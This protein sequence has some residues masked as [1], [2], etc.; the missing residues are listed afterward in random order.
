[1]QVYPKAFHWIIFSG[2]CSLTACQPVSSTP[3]SKVNANISG[4]STLQLSAAAKEKVGRKIW[5]NESGG[6]LEGL[7]QWNDGEE[8]PSLGIGHFIWYPAGFNGPY[9]ESFPMFVQYAMQRGGQEM[10]A[11]VK[12]TRH[13]PWKNKAAFLRDFNNPQLV[14]LRSYLA[15]NVGLQ[16]DFIVDRSRAALA[17]VL[18]A[19]PASQR[20]RIKA[21]YDKVASTSNGTYALIDYVN[22]KGDGTSPSERY[23]S[24]G[25][26]L[27]WVLM[28]MRTV[29]GGQAAA[30]EFAQAAKR[31][32]D[33]RIKNAP[34]ARS[35]E[36]W[37]AG[38]H[39]R[40][41][42]YKKPL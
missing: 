28:E 7:T 2:L 37:R 6:T 26:G 12:S 13:A 39:N 27:L 5:Q 42:T 10:P 15:R 1:M 33:R 41:D 36:R 17:K 18:A 21:N 32:L 20:A 34:A 16:T 35:E 40:C 29:P 30:N 14:E 22:F 9:K 23:N 38:W 8:F 25:W 19:A 3:P 4:S 11:W 31:C 24:Q